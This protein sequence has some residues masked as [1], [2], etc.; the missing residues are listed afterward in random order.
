MCHPLC[1]FLGKQP[2]H[3]AG[4]TRDGFPWIT[5]VVISTDDVLS[6]CREKLGEAA[7]KAGQRDQ[8]PPPEKEAA[9]ENGDHGPAVRTRGPRPVVM[10]RVIAEMTADLEKGYDLAGAT[11]EELSTKYG[12]ASRD[13]C[14]K[15]RSVVLSLIVAK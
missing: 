15:A 1:P 13:T 5:A 3:P 12:P 4:Q 8:S 7:C 11:E 9:A 6:K 2:A 10:P 14:R